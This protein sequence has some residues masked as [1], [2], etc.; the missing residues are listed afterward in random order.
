MSPFAG[1]VKVD[2]SYFGGVRKGR[3]GCR[4]K[5]PGFRAFEKW[6]EGLHSEDPECLYAGTRG[7]GIC[8]TSSLDN[9]LENR[10]LGHQPN[11][12]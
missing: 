8:D 2:D 7:S 3:S 9:P 6:R 5:S 1:E 12:Q 11:P 4:W 10:G